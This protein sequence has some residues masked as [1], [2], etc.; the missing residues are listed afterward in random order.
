MISVTSIVIRVIEI[1]DQ[2]NWGLE[3]MVITEFAAFEQVILPQ[4]V[5]VVPKILHVG[6]SSHVGLLP[7]KLEA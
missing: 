1:N 6:G 5:A 7:S 3:K 2:P 4:D